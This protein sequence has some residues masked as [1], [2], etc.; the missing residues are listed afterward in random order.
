MT[1]NW[2]WLTPLGHVAVVWPLA[3]TVV[4]NLIAE[5]GHPGSVKGAAIWIGALA[6]A[7]LMVAASEVA[8]YG[9]GIGIRVWDLTCFSGHTVLA[10]GF[11]PVCMALLISPSHPLARCM[12]VIAGTGLAMA[13][14]VSRAI[15]GFHPWSE[16]VAGIVPG[17]LIATLGLRSLRL[18]QLTI[19]R[20]TAIGAIIVSLALWTGARTS[21][22]TEALFAKLGSALSGQERPYRRS[23]WNQ[24]PSPI[25]PAPRRP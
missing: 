3:L 24:K 16:V 4:A 8:F 2:S 22:T 14:A 6:V 13:V 7:S 5:R 23:D 10:M 18:Q 19:N 1:W 17:A 9:W 12:A 21:W 20:V 15:L 25:E 11:W